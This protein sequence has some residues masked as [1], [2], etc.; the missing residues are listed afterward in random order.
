MNK[1]L[2]YI[3]ALCF[4]GVLVLGVV[5]VQFAGADKASETEQYKEILKTFFSAQNISYD[6]Q[7]RFDLEDTSGI[8][9]KGKIIKK[10][11]DYVDSN[12]QYYRILA[13]N[14]F[15]N[16]DLGMQSVF[17]VDIQ[18]M[19]QKMGFIREDLNNGLFDVTD[20]NYAALGTWRILERKPD[21]TVHVEFKVNDST[22]QMIRKV[23]FVFKDRSIENM[24]V[25]FTCAE[26]IQ[27]DNGVKNL[28]VRMNN[29][30]T[31]SI[32][33]NRKI[34]EV[35]RLDKKANPVLVNRFRNFQL[36]QL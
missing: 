33:L 11:A 23:E 26:A 1:S 8:S 9:S 36:K 34:A 10:G 5:L 27:Q 31:D 15:L 30:S 24:A 18:K 2:K 20:S 3:L 13:G 14:T 19:E 17:V 25:H 12:E 4:T 32:D 16:I 21:A 29:F 28:V 6:Y 22:A 35:V 7:A